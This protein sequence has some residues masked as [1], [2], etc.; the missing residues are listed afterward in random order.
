MD[1]YTAV[2]NGKTCFWYLY[3]KFSIESTQNNL[4]V[5]NI[6]FLKPG[7]CAAVFDLFTEMNC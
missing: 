3:I 7:Y 2:L 4:N 1:F 6:D 5:S